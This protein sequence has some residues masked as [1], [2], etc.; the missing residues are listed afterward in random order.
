MRIAGEGRTVR[1]GGYVVKNRRR[2]VTHA[3]GVGVILFLDVEV[4]CCCSGA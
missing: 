3:G 2:L 4:R 1:A